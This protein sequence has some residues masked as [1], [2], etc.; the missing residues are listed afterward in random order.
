MTTMAMPKPH[1]DRGI[2]GN[3][4]KWYASTTAKSMREFQELAERVARE[5][6]NGGTVL[7]VAPGPGYFCIEL[8]KLGP[9]AVRGVDL[10]HSMVEIARKKAA[11]AGVE[12]EFQQGNS[13]NLPFPQATFD[14]LVCRAAFKNFAQPVKALEEM[15]RVLKPGGRALLIDLRRDVSPAVVS[16]AVDR[17]GLGLLNRAITKLTF[18]FMLLKN[19]YT[20]EHLQQMLAQTHFSNVEIDAVDI[21]LEVRMSK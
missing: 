13:S 7:E 15:E 10:S 5:L 1:R 20:K 3:L 14:Y 12:V 11:A 17:M 4:A 16:Q 9:Y 18:R 8:A 19:A 21:G 6:P 2:E